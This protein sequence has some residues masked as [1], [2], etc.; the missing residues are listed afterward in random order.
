MPK[1][2]LK[3]LAIIMDGNR[4][5]A[6]ERGLPS[7]LGH[8]KGYENSLKVG[9]WCLKRNIKILTLWAFSTENWQ[10]SQKEISYLFNLTKF[11]LKKKGNLEKIFN[12]W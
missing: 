7:V 9:D 1:P 3:H 5:W 10:R 8:K 6:R 11:A 4:R 2:I 12:S